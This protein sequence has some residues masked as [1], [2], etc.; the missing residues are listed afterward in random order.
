MANRPRYGSFGGGWATGMHPRGP[1]GRFIHVSGGRVRRPTLAYTEGYVAAKAVR[2]TGRV[3]L[4]AAKLGGRAVVGTVKYTYRGGKAVG[5]GAVHLGVRGYRHHRVSV[6]RREAF[7]QLQQADRASMGYRNGA[8]KGYSKKSL[9][10]IDRSQRRYDRAV[11]R[12]AM[13]SARKR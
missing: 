6:T 9:Q 7:H 1:S 12:L 4:G 2:T 11:S 10:S 8:P 3:Y 5:I 13:S